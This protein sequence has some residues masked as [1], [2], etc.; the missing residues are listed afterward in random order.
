MQLGVSQREGPVGGGG[1][2]KKTKQRNSSIY[3]AVGHAVRVEKLPD[4]NFIMYLQYG[5]AWTGLLAGCVQGGKSGASPRKN[6]RIST[7]LGQDKEHQAAFEMMRNVLA[8]V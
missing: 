4:I 5:C 3:A 2:G 8:I 7:F 1:G 6:G